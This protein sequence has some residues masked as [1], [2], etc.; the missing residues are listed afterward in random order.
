MRTQ[1]YDTAIKKDEILL[2]VTIWLDLVGIMLGE[3]RSMERL[4]NL[5]KVIEG[6]KVELGVKTRQYGFKIFSS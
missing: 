1:E 5:P 6:A 2:L 4:S 3:I